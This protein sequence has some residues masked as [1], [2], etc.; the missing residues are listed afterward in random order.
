MGHD[1]PSLD[2][3][4]E[5]PSVLLPPKCLVQAHT[6]QDVELHTVPLEPLN[7]RETAAPSPTEQ[8]TN[9]VLSKL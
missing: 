8:N 3:A 4:E 6:G 9:Q 1:G 7:Q 5:I 2:S